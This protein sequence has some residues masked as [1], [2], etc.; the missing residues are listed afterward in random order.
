MAKWADYVIFRVRY[1]SAFTH[2]DAVE[3]ADDTDTAFG[4][5]RVETRAS[6]IF[7]L[8]MGRTYITVPLSPEG[9]ITKG[10]NVTPVNVNGVTYIRTDANGLARDNLDNL[11]TF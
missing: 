4:P 7:N 5:K 8:A 1:N 11:P 3:V 10:A 9:N 2:I 6:V